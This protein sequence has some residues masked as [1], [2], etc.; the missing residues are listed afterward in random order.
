MP[1][2]T[3]FRTQWSVCPFLAVTRGHWRVGTELLV[4]LDEP[5]GFFG[6]GQ[7]IWAAALKVGAWW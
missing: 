3:L 7:R 4:N 2:A 1:T 6:M 5:Y